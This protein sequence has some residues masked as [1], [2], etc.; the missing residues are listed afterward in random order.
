M[1]TSHG[2][3]TKTVE[4]STLKGRQPDYE[5]ELLHRLYEVLPQGV[6]VTVWCPTGG[7]PTASC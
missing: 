3:A 1:L 6:E 5:D 7:L 4:S 2:L